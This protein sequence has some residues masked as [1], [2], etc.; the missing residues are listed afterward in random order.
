MSSRSA[1]A[2]MYF[3]SKYQKWPPKKFTTNYIFIYRNNTN[4]IDNASVNPRVVFTFVFPVSLWNWLMSCLKYKNYRKLE[5]GCSCLSYFSILWKDL[6]WWLLL[7]NKFSIRL[8]SKITLFPVL[9]LFGKLKCSS[10]MRPDRLKA[11][12]FLGG[13]FR[14]W[15]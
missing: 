8:K 15:F 1:W 11:H 14:N 9:F 3:A 12:L 5:I 13:S 7:V 6:C 10:C 2:T 4:V